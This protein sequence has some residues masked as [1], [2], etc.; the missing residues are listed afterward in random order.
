MTALESIAYLAE[1]QSTPGG[2]DLLKECADR[3]LRYVPGDAEYGHEEDAVTLAHAC[4][5]L[6]NR[7]LYAGGWGL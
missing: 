2:R 6:M 7:I 5:R 3:G 1:A 4:V